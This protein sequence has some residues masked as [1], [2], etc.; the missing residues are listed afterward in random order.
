MP[1]INYKSTNSNSFLNLSKILSNDYYRLLLTQILE[2]EN[3]ANKKN[4]KIEKLELLFQQLETQKVENQ[5]KT[6]FTTTPT[7][8]LNTSEKIE[9]ESLTKTTINY[10]NAIKKSIQPTK[11]EILNAS[12]IIKI[13]FFLNKKIKTF[14]LTTP[15]LKIF[16]VNIGDACS[17]ELNN[18]TIALCGKNSSCVNK[19]CECVKFLKEKNGECINNTFNKP[20]KIKFQKTEV[21]KYLFSC[22]FC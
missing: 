20:S 7:I 3:I 4:E 18:N 19:R 21:G 6:I 10:F 13:G 5:L 15:L 16:L 14:N 12:Q 17:Q 2:N 8:I 22:L 11:S 9:A 1:K